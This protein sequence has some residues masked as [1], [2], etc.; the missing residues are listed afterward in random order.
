[1]LAI[2]AWCRP[3]TNDQAEILDFMEMVPFE[4]PLCSV[5]YDCSLADLQPSAAVTYAVAG[6]LVLALGCICMYFALH[7]MVQMLRTS[8]EEMGEE[9]EEDDDSNDHARDAKTTQNPKDKG[10]GKPNPIVA[11]VGPCD[12]Q[13]VDL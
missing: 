8:A 7:V 5:Q 13:L 1:M 10:K 6:T 3:F 2:A 4:L 11:L 12:L 9:V